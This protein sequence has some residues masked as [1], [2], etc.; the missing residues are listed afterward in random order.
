MTGDL[1]TL[2]VSDIKHPAVDAGVIHRNYILV[3]IIRS[4]FSVEWDIGMAV[5]DW[6]GINMQERLIISW[7]EIPRCSKNSHNKPPHPHNNQMKVIVLIGSDDLD[8][9]NPQFKDMIHQQFSLGGHLDGLSNL[10]RI[11]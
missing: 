10:I 5:K 1:V 4:F 9:L 7:E 6:N 3:V 8:K 2:F 11:D